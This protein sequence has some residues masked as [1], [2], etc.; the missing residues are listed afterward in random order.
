MSPLVPPWTISCVT[1]LGKRGAN[2]RAWA[3]CVYRLCSRTLLVGSVQACFRH[4]L[5]LP[6]DTQDEL[7]RASLEQHRAQTCRHQGTIR[8]WSNCPWPPPPSYLAAPAR[9]AERGEGKT[10]AFWDAVGNL[11]SKA[12][13]LVS[14]M[15]CLS[16]WE[17]NRIWLNPHVRGH[18][19]IPRPPSDCEP[20]AADRPGLGLAWSLWNHV[21]VATKFCN[22]DFLICQ[23][24]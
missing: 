16:T 20:E 6:K 4:S 12:I 19:G 10:E 17:G 5:A 2:S 23:R 24:D 11:D 13:R 8:R 22:P 21:P 15:P 9:E 1:H 7:P 14:T 18:K 3:V